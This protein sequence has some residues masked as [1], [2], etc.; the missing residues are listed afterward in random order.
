FHAGGVPAVLSRIRDLL[1]LDCPTVNGATVGE[2]IAHAASRNDSVIRTREE[3]LQAEGGIAVLYGNLAPDGAVLKQSAASSQ[4]LEHRGPA[5]VFENRE[6]MLANIDREDLPVD[7]NSVLVMRNCGPKG[8][9]G[10]PEWGQIPIPRKLLKQ[11][12]TDM[13][14]LSD[15]RMSGTSFGTVVL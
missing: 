15:A 14:R 1:H 2:N 10:F 11:G 3:P 12:V 8:G 6:E 9:P 13:V 7:A 5:Y 4:L